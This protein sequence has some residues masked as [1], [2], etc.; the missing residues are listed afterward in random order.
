MVWYIG[1]SPFCTVLR[2]KN[3][4]AAKISQKVVHWGLSLMYHFFIK[5][6]FKSKNS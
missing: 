2:E 3:A 4:D 1:D 6:T 5:I